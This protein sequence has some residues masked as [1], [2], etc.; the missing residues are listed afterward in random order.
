MRAANP[1]HRRLNPNLRH[2][3]RV[4]RR[5]IDRLRRWPQFGNQTLA[6]PSRR[7]DAMSAIPQHAVLQLRYQH[8]ALRAPRIE[9]G[10]QIVLLLIHGWATWV[11]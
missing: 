3:L 7:F 2:A 10:D 8:T 9:H 6:H 4:Q 11:G 1:N 5:A